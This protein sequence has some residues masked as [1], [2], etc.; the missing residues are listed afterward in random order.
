[1]KTYAETVDFL[2]A[3]LPVFQRDGAAAYKPG[4][5][6]TI[7][8]CAEIGNPQLRLR[9]VHVGGTNGKGSSSHSIA[10]VLQESGFKTGLYTSPH[11]V[12]FRERIRINGACI[13]ESYV[14][15]RIQNWL[16]I[17]DRLK[18][19][20][21]EL[22][23][24]LAFDYFAENEVDIA[25]IEVGMGGRLDS[26]NVILPEVSL[27]TNISLDHQKFLGN[28]PEAIAFEKAGIIKAGIPVV[29][30][31]RQA[32][33]DAVFIE[34]AAAC[35][36]PLYFGDAC[37][38]VADNGMAGNERQ[39]FVNQDIGNKEFLVNL[40]L[41]GKY[42]LKNLP[43]ILKVLEILKGHGW[44]IPAAAI[45]K[46]L[47]K[48]QQNTGL[49]GRWQILRTKPLLVCDTGHNEAGIRELVAQI[50]ATPYH[51]LWIIWAMVDDKDHEK[52]VKLLPADSTFILTE[53]SLPR[54]LR[55]EELAKIF[56]QL[57]L[58]YELMPSVSEAI[59][60]AL[61]YANKGDLI[62]VGGST[63]TVAEIPFHKF[64]PLH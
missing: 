50:A 31:E 18:P 37:F 16:P 45:E 7:A 4:L 32:G 11:L 13:P 58:G 19:S 63:F 52:I 38:F 34:K 36:A 26:T 10:S 40:S 24:A 6:T 43:G 14:V 22:T 20:F 42:Q 64:L 29:V 61:R 55:K 27:I 15:E 5:D 2:F 54:A 44:I 17:I 33:V 59:D 60:Y 28:T 8:F 21:F 57:Q 3:Q 25:V 12:D 47:S 56:D 53:F 1:M 41:T 23:V 39:V 49:M 9:C 46:G 30:S 48:V 51:K 35:N 62:L